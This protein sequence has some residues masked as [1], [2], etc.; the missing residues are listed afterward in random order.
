[1]ELVFCGRIHKRR[2]CGSDTDEE[3][4]TP[5]AHSRSSG[6]RMC[7]GIGSTAAMK[8][9][10]GKAME[11]WSKE[12]QFMVREPIEPRDVF[13]NCMHDTLQENDRMRIIWGSRQGRI[14]VDGSHMT[15][16]LVLGS[17]VELSNNAPPLLL[18]LPQ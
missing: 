13:E 10:G 16:D 4:I 8:S 2:G 3:F 11:R 17:I 15:Q 1:M 9:G 5:L 7:T 6:L 18:Y 14:Y 12:L